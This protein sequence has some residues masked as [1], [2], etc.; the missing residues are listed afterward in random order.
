MV[1]EFGER[2]QKIFHIK[3]LET[4]QETRDRANGRHWMFAANE[5]TEL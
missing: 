1:D 3:P 5:R 2:V 4:K